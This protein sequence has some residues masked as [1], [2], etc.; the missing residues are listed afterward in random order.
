MWSRAL[1]PVNIREIRQSRILIGALILVIGGAISY[2]LPM[3]HELT[4][5]QV[6]EFQDS[7]LSQRLRSLDASADFGSEQLIDALDDPNS[8]VRAAAV[9]QL[10]QLGPLL[11]KSLERLRE[12]VRGDTNPDVRGSAAIALALCAN[13]NSEIINE[14]VALFQS[15]PDEERPAFANAL[16]EIGPQCFDEITSLSADQRPGV[17]E[18]TMRIIWEA[19]CGDPVSPKMARRVIDAAR[20]NPSRKTEAGKRIAWRILLR[21]QSINTQDVRLAFESVDPHVVEFGLSAV[22]SGQVADP[23]LATIIADLE[24]GPASPVQRLAAL[25]TLGPA[26]SNAMPFVLDPMKERSDSDWATATA[27]MAFVAAAAMHADTAVLEEFL[28]SKWS[29]SDML[30]YAQ[31][32]NDNARFNNIPD[33]IRPAIA[34]RLHELNAS[35][36]NKASENYVIELLVLLGQPPENAIESLTGRLQDTKT[37]PQAARLLGEFGI[38]ARTAVPELLRVLKAIRSSRLEFAYPASREAMQASFL[39]ALGR[40]GR[41]DPDVVAGINA[42]RTTTASRNTSATYGKTAEANRCRCFGLIA[43][44][45][46]WK[47]VEPENLAATLK[48][49]TLDEAATVR[50]L[51]AINLDLIDDEHQRCQLIERCLADKS[52]F[53]S[54]AAALSY[55]RRPAESTG[56]IRALQ[57]ARDRIGSHKLHPASRTSVVSYPGSSIPW[58]HRTTELRTTSLRAAAQRALSVSSP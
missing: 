57:H 25:R 5:M 51:A 9:V 54:R 32:G 12:T 3:L 8:S 39:I 36:Q 49:A 43:A 2:T 35:M 45:E 11:E 19:G 46:Y 48:D 28:S 14:L 17:R 42:A 53:V 58:Q 52:D 13:S 47:N 50:L 34:A 23:N 1:S 6:V 38:A 4:T 22:T 7:P 10:G 31:H 24:S 29:P 20:R 55:C 21:E 27:V 15:V 40:I 30:Y 16:I 56:M 41:D 18:Q 26:A 44:I 37:G 33:S